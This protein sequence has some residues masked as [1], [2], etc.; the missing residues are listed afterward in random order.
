M[1]LLIVLVIIIHQPSTTRHIEMVSTV[2]LSRLARHAHR[3][4]TSVSSAHMEKT[5]PADT[6]FLRMGVEFHTTS[7]TRGGYSEE[8]RGDAGGD[9]GKGN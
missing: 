4:S 8:Y 7:G 2:C 3:Q 5:R 6:K 9:T 1:I